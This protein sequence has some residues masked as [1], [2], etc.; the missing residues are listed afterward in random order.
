M[1]KLQMIKI[2][3]NSDEENIW[4]ESMEVGEDGSNI[5]E[6]AI[7]AAAMYELFGKD[8]DFETFVKGFR[9]IAKKKMEE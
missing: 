1:E 7:I 9:K 5:G 6:G 4:I 3:A 2:I 8:E